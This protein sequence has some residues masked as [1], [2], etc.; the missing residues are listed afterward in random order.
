VFGCWLFFSSTA[1]PGETIWLLDL[2]IGAAARPRDSLVVGY[3]VSLVVT[4]TA[5]IWLLDDLVGEP[6]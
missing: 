2:L 1:S 4:A 3:V 5:K 6:S